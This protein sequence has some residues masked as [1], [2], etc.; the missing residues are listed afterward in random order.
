MACL[1]GHNWTWPRRR[2][3]KDIQVC[4][5]CHSERECPVQFDGPW[6]KKTQDGVPN[7]STVTVRV[8]EVLG[9]SQLSTG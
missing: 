9:T 5:N 8:P 6:Y 4:L 2:G 1:F 7:P 3:G